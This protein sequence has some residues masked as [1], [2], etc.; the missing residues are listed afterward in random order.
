MREIHKPDVLLAWRGQGTGDR[1]MRGRAASPRPGAVGQAVAHISQGPGQHKDPRE[2][3]ETSFLS[4]MV[5]K[6]PAIFSLR[7]RACL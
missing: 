6:A 1:G 3:C 2:I 5:E 4:G 7:L